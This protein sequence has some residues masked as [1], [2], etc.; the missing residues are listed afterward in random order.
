MND[1]NLAI[2]NTQVQIAIKNLEPR[3]LDPVVEQLSALPLDAELLT[4]VQTVR[5]ALDAA[6][7]ASKY[8]KQKSK[9]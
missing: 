4:V 8:N 9:R 5:Y 6:L 2:L 7:H 1:R 3:R